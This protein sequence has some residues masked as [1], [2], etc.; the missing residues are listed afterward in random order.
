MRLLHTSDW[1]LGR[2]FH[3]VSLLEDQRYVL[4]QLI[5]VVRE[6]QVDVV[7]IAGDIY[8][9]SVPPADAVSL[10]NAILRTLCI[11]M[12]VPVVMISGNH[13]GAERLGFGADLL[14]ASGLYILSH[15]DN[16]K[17]PLD[18]T[19]GQE[20]LRFYGIPY[21]SPEEVRYRFDTDVQTFDEAHS[22]LVTQ[23]TDTL[24]TSKRN[25]L[26]SHCF[27]S[28]SEASESERPLSIGGADSVAWEPMRVFDYVALGHLHA[29]QYRGE[30]HIRY[31]GSLLKY[32][33]SE[34][35]Q[36]KGVTLVD[37]DDGLAPM[38]PV[39]EK[40]HLQPRRDMRI[41]EG[42]FAHILEQAKTDE[43]S[44]DYLL[45]RL[46]DT[47][48]ILDAVGKLRYFYPNLLHLEKPGMAGANQSAELAREQLKRS[49]LDMFAD[50]FNQS[51]NQPMTD[52]Q[53]Q[54]ITEIIKAIHR[55]EA[56]Q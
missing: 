16:F 20:Q 37:I 54:A 25:I 46:T 1:H 42:A 10:L 4:E 6:Q 36:Q 22:W 7:V 44:E 39:I 55:S 26:L 45:I 12:N 29:P 27:V 14:Q 41:I 2:Q 19:V 52:E 38:P 8:D 35:T 53:T 21:C 17:K 47:T 40:I 31:S 51:H 50:F 13:D 43:N 48:A 9:R 32:S 24:D 23:I 56:R 28:G 5:T 33:F 49:E 30:Q 34:V 18:L 15:L 11:D 3:N